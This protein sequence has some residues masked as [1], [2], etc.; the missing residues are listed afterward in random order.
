MNRQFS[1]LHISDLHKPQNSDFDSLFYSLQTD[2]FSYVTSGIDKPQII[3]VSGD[4]I[5]GSIEENAEEIIK[6]QY[7]EV[8]GFLDKLVEFFLDG[9][10]NRLIVVPGNHDC[11]FSNS[12]ASMHVAP[13]ARAREDYKSMQESDP[14]VRWNWDDRKFY[15]IDNKD[16]YNKR[17]DL[18]KWFFNNY[19]RGIR[20]FPAHADR[21]S[22]IVEL[23]LYSIAFV[24]FNSCYRLD[25][26][27][28]AGCISPDAITSACARLRELKKMGYFLVGV[29][30]HHVSGLPSENN[31]M[32]YR[33][34]DAMMQE[35][36]QLGLFGHQHVSSAVREYSDITS[37]QSILLISSGSLYGN[38]HQLV[39]GVPRQYN[40]I[41]LS[42]KGKDVALHLHVRKDNSRDGYDIPH[43]IQSPIGINSLPQYDHSFVV[44]DIQLE[45]LVSDIDTMVK[46]SGNY[47]EACERLLGLGLENEIV[48]KYF[49]SYVSMIGNTLT[50]KRLL[51]NPVSVT[52]YMVALDSAVINKDVEWIKRL[53]EIDCFKDCTELYVRDLRAKAFKIL[54]I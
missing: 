39:T 15:H 24:C 20:E 27:N 44:D 42:L 22:F 31:Y 3:V 11:C 52:Q 21:D 50:L 36:I 14:F 18:F 7:S 34:L 1:I 30:H 41:D 37:K 5:E 29:W 48:L 53:L 51:A 6:S 13:E 47:E 25:H 32:D 8:G 19:F 16:E 10:K 26:L 38:R 35:G 4:L 28:P 54:G 40:V 45:Y 49:D 46:N 2:C 9:D 33:I 43:W 23:P 12:Q 17:F